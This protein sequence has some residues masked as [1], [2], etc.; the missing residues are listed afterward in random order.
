MNLPNNKQ[1]LNGG[2]M[3]TEPVELKK[4]NRGAGG[5]LL[6]GFIMIGI[7]LGFLFNFMPE[8][9]FFGIGAGLIVMA[10]W[11]YKTNEC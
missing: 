4:R 1:F 6:A 10:L 3:S 11:R 2:K 5:L 7:G 9:L 8:A